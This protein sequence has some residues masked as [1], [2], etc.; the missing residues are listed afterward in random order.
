MA[1]LWTNVTQP[2]AHPKISISELRS[3]LRCTAQHDYAY[4]Q[5][6]TPR[7][8]PGYFLKGTYL[9]EL[10][11]AFW[12]SVQRGEPLTAAECVNAALQAMAEDRE[13]PSPS[14]AAEVNDVFR[15]WHDDTVH[16]V[17][18]YEVLA[19]EQ[20]FLLD[21][22]LQHVT[23]LVDGGHARMPVLLH[24]IVDL[25]VR[26]SQGLVW[27]VEH[28]T[29]GRAWSQGNYLFD[30]QS[31]LYPL[32]VEEY[33]A[34]LVAGTQFQFFYPKRYEVKLVSPDAADIVGFVNLVNGA[35]DL[36]ESGIIVPQPH[37][38][39]NDCSFKALCHAELTRNDSG[40][41]IRDQQY[42][43]DQDRVDR[44]SEEAA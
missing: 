43:V 7:E 16:R 12:A 28:K 39:C 36:R 31:R 30:L 38:G 34:E 6:L 23:V 18:D 13:P 35:I 10:Q 42:T 37:W 22:G 40:E 32:A 24:G 3:L 29:A 14:D 26:D 1:E 44:F 41:Y 2:E 19:V 11:A 9:H 5:G 15:A 25:V 33:L 8:T 4:R 20:E 21:I 27:V 17:S